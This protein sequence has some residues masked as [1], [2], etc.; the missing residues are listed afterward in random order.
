MPAH[1]N[2]VCIHL[3]Y[4]LLGTVIELTWQRYEP[5]R[6]YVADVRQ[7]RLESTVFDLCPLL[8]RMGDRD[9]ACAQGV[10]APRR[11]KH[12]EVSVFDLYLS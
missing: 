7:R 1:S 9:P 10:P 8:A 3:L 4:Y 5:F 12:Q 11:R 6:I 2:R